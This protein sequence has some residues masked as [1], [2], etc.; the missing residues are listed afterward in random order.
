ME[1]DFELRPI[2]TPEQ[3]EAAASLMAKCGLQPQQCEYSIGIFDANGQ[4]VACAG[5][6]GYVVKGVAVEPRLRVKAFTHSLISHLMS[7]YRGLVVQGKVKGISD[8]LLQGV[9][10]FTKPLYRRVF[11]SYGMKVIAQAEQAVLLE[12][13][14]SG[15]ELYC[16]QLKELSQ[17]LEGTKGVI[18]MNA[19]PLTRG[20]HYL[21]K[22]ACQQVD[23]LFIIPVMEDRSEF[24]YSE[25]Y[26]MLKHLEDLHPNVHVMDGS[27]YVISSA[28]FPTYFIKEASEIANTHIELDCNL[29]GNHIV[30]ALGATVRFVGSEPDDPLTNRYNQAMKR[31]LPLEVVEIPRLEAH[32][33]PISASRVRRAIKAGNLHDAWD[34]LDSDESRAHVLSHAACEAL[35]QCCENPAA[36]KPIFA[37]IAQ[38]GLSETD[39]DLLKT[40]AI[41]EVLPASKSSTDLTSLVKAFADALSAAANSLHAHGWVLKDALSE[42]WR[43]TGSNLALDS[44]ID[45]ALAPVQEFLNSI[46]TP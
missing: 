33:K 43:R 2:L 29:F 3:L 17:D 40:K 14:P 1:L 8:P 20:H 31:L 5:L 38:P 10:L 18:V 39:L 45:H 44:T 12:A 7:Y 30:P 23:N 21:V 4:L 16:Q 41:A 24:S 15:L 35:F 46:T 22:Q 26:R 36:F 13:L 6:D 28:T 42:G 11:S 19:N 34:L 27:R 9:M 32:G 37:E 25:R